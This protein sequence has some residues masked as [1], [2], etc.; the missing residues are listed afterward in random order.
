MHYRSSISLLGLPLVEVAFGG[1]GASPRRGAR[2]WIAIGDVAFGI[3]FAG[4]GVAVGGVAMG[5]AAV[6]LLSLGGGSLGGLAIGGLAVGVAAVGGGAF[7]LWGAVGGLA[8]AGEVALGGLAIAPHANDAAARAALASGP[9]RLATRLLAE[10]R[11]LV[12]L[13][14]ILTLVAL[15]RLARARGVERPGR[16]RR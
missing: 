10:S 9:L 12:L 14:L 4:G 6:G 3:L 13:A 16:G 15:I 2:A 7:G 8:L 1:G 11:W 5:G